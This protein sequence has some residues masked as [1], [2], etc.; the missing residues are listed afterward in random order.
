MHIFH[1]TEQN[2]K[3]E[4]EYKKKELGSCGVPPLPP[5]NS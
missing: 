1:E 5:K 4:T 2:W 3:L